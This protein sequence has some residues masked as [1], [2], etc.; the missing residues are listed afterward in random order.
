MIDRDEVLYTAD[1]LQDWKRQAENRARNETKGKTEY[2]PIAPS[3]LHTQLTSGERGVL[4]ALED[5]FGCEVK[6]PAQVPFEQ[7]WLNLH[8]AVVRREDLIAIEIYEYKG[9]GFPYFAIR[10][11]INTGPKLPF[12][13]FRKFVLYVAVVSDM[14]EELDEPIRAQLN[15]LASSALTSDPP[16]EVYIRMYRL[17][18]LLAKYNL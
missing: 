12:L 16:C 18:A 9:G 3:E 7:G 11:L 17:K 15:Q 4:R 1:V 10:H 6:T 14:A 13:R 8:A 5:E 2:R